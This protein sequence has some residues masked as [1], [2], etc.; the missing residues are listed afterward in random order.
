MDSARYSI[1]HDNRT[2]NINKDESIN[3][4]QGRQNTQTQDFIFTSTNNN[5]TPSQDLEK[6]EDSFRLKQEIFQTIAESD[7]QDT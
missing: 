1:N 4:L 5:Q 7:V 3:T 2:L 6:N